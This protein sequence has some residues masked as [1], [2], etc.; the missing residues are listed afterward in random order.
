MKYLATFILSAIVLCSFITAQSKSQP[1]FT[2]ERAP[3]NRA[4]GPYTA[5]VKADEAQFTLPAPQQRELKWRQPETKDNTQEYR[6][7]IVKADEAQFTLPAPQ[8]REL[9]WRQP[10]TKD[11]TQEYRM[12]VTVKNGG[13]E[14]TFGFYLWKRAGAEPAQGSFSELLAAGQKSLFERPPS[15]SGLALVPNAGLK[16][17][18]RSDTLL[19][20]ISGRNNVARLFSG[21]P[22]DV[23]FTITVPG[24]SPRRELVPVRYEG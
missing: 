19:I 23:T 11:N 21:K 9:K 17:S 16:V 2:T 15:A 5:I 6:T 7:A 18:E 3:G 1:N 13:T 20:T 24:H 10:E 4:A 14:Y 22:S 8:Q 12:D